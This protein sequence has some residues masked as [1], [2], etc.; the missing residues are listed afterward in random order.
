MS[1]R[2]F[3]DDEDSE[4][5]RP[6]CQTVE[7]SIRNLLSKDPDTSEPLDMTDYGDHGVATST[8]LQSS[9]LLAASAVLVPWAASLAYAHL[10]S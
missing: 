8:L 3:T 4:E 5:K 2:Y 10:V 6:P 9:V 7:E 1:L